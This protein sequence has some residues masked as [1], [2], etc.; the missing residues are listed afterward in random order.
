MIKDS[1]LEELTKHPFISSKTII[2]IIIEKLVK[3]YSC[4][5]KGLSLSE[6]EEN[7]RDLM[8]VKDSLILNLW[9]R[10]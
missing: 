5:R 7:K 10:K 1:W 8:L 6:P 9:M 3:P 4:L 2:L